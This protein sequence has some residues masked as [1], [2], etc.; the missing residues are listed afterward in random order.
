MTHCHSKGIGLFVSIEWGLK[1]LRFFGP[2]SFSAKKDGKEFT[3]D[4]FTSPYDQNMD[5]YLPSFISQYVIIFIPNKSGDNCVLMTREDCIS[6]QETKVS[7]KWIAE[8]I[9]R[10]WN[11]R[12]T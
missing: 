11:A 8:R 9:K 1:N 7:M 6:S 10:K 12:Q 2:H 4:V 5:V 3:F